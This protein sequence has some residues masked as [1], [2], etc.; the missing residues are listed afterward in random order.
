M[1]GGADLHIV[2]NVYVQSSWCGEAY[3]NDY[4][5]AYSDIAEHIQYGQDN[6]RSHAEILQESSLNLFLRSGS[7]CGG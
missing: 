7:M 4:I 1:T 2:A 6:F 5:Q 3:D